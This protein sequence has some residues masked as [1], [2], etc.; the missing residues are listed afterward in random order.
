[1]T[2]TKTTSAAAPDE[3]GRANRVINEA[4]YLDGNVITHATARLIAAA[5]HPGPGSALER[6]AASGQFDI[7]ILRHELTQLSLEPFQ[8]P[9]RDAVLDYLDDKRVHHPWTRPVIIP[10]DFGRTPRSTRP[11]SGPETD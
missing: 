10:R 11:E 8:R 5:I 7:A 2:N 1:M 3:S 9:W 6:L 4:I